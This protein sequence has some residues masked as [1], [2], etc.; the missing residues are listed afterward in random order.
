MYDYPD[1]QDSI[2]YDTIRK[3][4]FAPGYWAASERRILDMLGT[5]LCSIAP[6]SFLDIGCGEGRLVGE[7]QEFSD[8]VTALEPDRVRF[9]SSR[10]SFARHGWTG[11]VDLRRCVFEDFIAE[12][13]YDFVLCSHILQHIS[14]GSVVPF[15]EKMAEVTNRGGIAAVMTCHSVR[16]TEYF[17]VARHVSDSEVEERDVSREEFESH[18]TSDGVLPIHFFS[19]GFLL[20]T[21]MNAGFDVELVQVFHVAADPELHLADPDEYVNSSPELQRR[22]GRDIFLLLKKI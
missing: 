15:I 16:D 5:R 1:R 8:A 10:E 2:T 13:G 18:L 21:C 17:A 3:I 7:F 11:K 22:Y 19:T 4:E 20:E 9:E 6:V 12:H 14:A